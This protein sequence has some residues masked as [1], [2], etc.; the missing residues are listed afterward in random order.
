MNISQRHQ[1]IIAMIREKKHIT[2]SEISKLLGV[3]EVTIRKDFNYLE[4]KSLIFRHHGGASLNNPYASDL[5][6]SQKQN[7]K[8][9]EKNKIA[10]KAVSFIEEND[11]IILGSGTTTYN[12]VSYLPKDKEITIITSSLLVAARLCE[13][14]NIQ[15]LQIGG[16]VRHSSQSTVGP[17][18]QQM[19][20]QF[21]AN[22]LFL[23]VDGIDKD[24]GI[25]TSNVEEAYLNQ[26]MI[27]NSNKS[28]VLCD[29]TKFG[30][31]GLGKICNINEIDCLITNQELDF[32]FE[33]ILA[34]NAV[35]VVVSE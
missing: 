5:P 19:M 16:N 35:N 29:E 9:D 15:I 28:F 11:V 4:E 24:F 18:A 22:K 33:S 17:N 3:S 13:F 6:I 1:E 27:K 10:E 31:K 12:M 7:I 34:K 21:S 23:G 20:L 25:S 14:P 8:I 26:L 30:K 32:E 2:V